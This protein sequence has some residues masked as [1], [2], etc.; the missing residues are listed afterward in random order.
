MGFWVLLSL[1]EYDSNF[2]HPFTPPFLS[3][4]LMQTSRAPGD[5][6]GYENGGGSLGEGIPQDRQRLPGRILNYSSTESPGTDS[7]RPDLMH[8]PAR[9]RRSGRGL[10]ARHRAMGLGGTGLRARQGTASTTDHLPG[11][12]ARGTFDDVSFGRLCRDFGA[13]F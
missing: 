5:P 7:E 4:I 13:P 3:M 1:V 10:R 2:R 12:H 11:A 9:L 6:S 8:N